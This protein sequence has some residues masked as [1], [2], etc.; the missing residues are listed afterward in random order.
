M[1]TKS[2]DPDVLG[3]ILSQA[4]SF[5]DSSRAPSI[6]FDLDDTLFDTGS[7]TRHILEEF[8]RTPRVMEAVPDLIHRIARVEPSRIQYS[9]LG[10]LDLLG[11]TDGDLRREGEKFWWDRFFHYSHVDH[12]NPGAVAYVNAVHQAGATIVYLSGRDEARML[13]ATKTSIQGHK[14][15]LDAQTRLILK[16]DPAMDDLEFKRTVFTRVVTAL[17]GAS[18]IIAGFE[19]EPRNLNLMHDL[20]P[21][22]Q[23]IFV[24][25]RHSDDPARPYPSIPWIKDFTG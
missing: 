14:M 23:A 10:N 18:N 16:P 20:L 24:H 11:I 6:V 7:R 1:K 8:A 19:N 2:Y 12:P 9:I 5:A 17:D 13:H 21:S 15:P 4:K 25:T 22:T 3:R